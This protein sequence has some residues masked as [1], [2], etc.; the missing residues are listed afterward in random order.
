MKMEYSIGYQH[1][2]KGASRPIGD[3]KIVAI[4]AD[5]EFGP[6]P[7]PNVG[8]FVHINN[9]AAGASRSSFQGR[10]RSRLFRYIRLNDERIFCHVN[11][12]VEDTDDDWGM[13]I[14]E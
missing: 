2:P 5:D 12:I 3:G 13:L 1:L 4:K 8:D 6:L 11:I 14:Q 7:L 9:S 10:V